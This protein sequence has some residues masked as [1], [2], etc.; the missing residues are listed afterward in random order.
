M[1]FMKNSRY[2]DR[3]ILLYAKDRYNHLFLGG[4]KIP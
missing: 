2:N 3:I 1:N 4:S